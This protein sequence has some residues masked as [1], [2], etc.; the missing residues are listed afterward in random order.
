[1]FGSTVVVGRAH[2]SGTRPENEEIFM[3]RIMAVAV[4][5][6]VGAFTTLARPE[7]P[8]N[9]PPQGFTAIFD[10]KS[11]GGWHGRQQTYSPYK[12]AELSKEEHPKKQAEWDADKEKHW[13]I[14]TAK[15]EIVSDG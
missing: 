8:L 9:Q 12:E 2:T 10:G 14:D 5:F 7:Q 6:F 3:R 15:G 4:G 11:L 1:M 13:S